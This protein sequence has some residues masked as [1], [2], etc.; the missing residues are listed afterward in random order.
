MLIE[1][2]ELQKIDHFSNPYS[3]FLHNSILIN[4][5]A[6]CYSCCE[7]LSTSSKVFNCSDCDF[8]LHKSCS[9]DLIEHYRDFKHILNSFHNHPL[10]IIYYD[11]EVPGVVYCIVYGKHCFGSTYVCKFYL[12]E[13][14]LDLMGTI[15]QNSFHEHPLTVIEQKVNDSA[16]Y[17][18]MN[19]VGAF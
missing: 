10:E 5:Y 19:V 16:S 3:L 4:G 13:Y 15:C 14:S 8:Y 11:R 12:H 17:F 2:P 1:F 18:A 6:S 7:Q 9:L